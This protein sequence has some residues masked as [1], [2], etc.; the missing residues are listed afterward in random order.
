MLSDVL[1]L[2]LSA[3]DVSGASGLGAAALAAS[4]AEI[5]GQAAPP[6]P[7]LVAEP[8]NDRHALYDNRYHQFRD[9][10]R[11]VR[12]KRSPRSGQ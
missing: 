6:A 9:M 10:V 7:R 2:P 3:V 4:A 1:G 8:E 12:D 5:A 11:A